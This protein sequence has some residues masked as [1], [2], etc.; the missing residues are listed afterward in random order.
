M[1]DFQIEPYTLSPWAKAKGLTHCF[2]Y[3]G[4][5][6][7]PT[8][9]NGD[10]LYL[11]SVAKKLVIGDVIVFTGPKRKRVIVHRI[12]AISPEGL[13]TRGDHNS[14]C[15]SPVVLEQVIGKVEITENKR[16]VGSVD[17][18][19]WGLWLA[20]I[21]HTVFWLER[22]FRWMFW[23]PYQLVRKSGI[24]SIIWRPKIVKIH[25]R[26]A[27][28]LRVKYIYK[29]RTVAIWDSDT[30]RFDCRKPFNLVIPHPEEL[31]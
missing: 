24:V 31:K 19:F 7:N 21:W 4:P 8:F 9:Q 18:G 1:S 13:I 10:F 5:S 28:G 26:K 12:I 22:L 25:I 23:S 2:V 15:D 30:Q 16:G 20:R 17:N 11:R 27:G 6:M 14:V 3:R 29:Q